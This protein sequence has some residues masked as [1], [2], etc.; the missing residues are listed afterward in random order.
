MRKQN[1]LSLGL[2]H[3]NMM[4]YNTYSCYSWIVGYCAMTAGDILPLLKI[5]IQWPSL[6]VFR[7]R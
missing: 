2:L 6:H 5:F 3:R 4:R 1:F 7:V